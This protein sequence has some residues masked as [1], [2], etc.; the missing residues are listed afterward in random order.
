[1]ATVRL[2]VLSSWHHPC[3]HTFISSAWLHSFFISPGLALR[4][5][6]DHLTSLSR[7]FISPSFSRLTDFQSTY[8]R[9]S[10]FLQVSPACFCFHSSLAV[11]LAYDPPAPAPQ[12]IQPFVFAFNPPTD[13]PIINLFPFSPAGLSGFPA[14]LFRFADSCIDGLSWRWCAIPSALNTG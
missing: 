5:A 3:S 4:S 6:Y 9:S 13:R 8:S 14:S 2:V 10:D 7:L 1:M 11:G 12:S